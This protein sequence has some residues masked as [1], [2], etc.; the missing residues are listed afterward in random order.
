MPDKYEVSVCVWGDFACFTRP[1]ARV[2]RV[3]Y[4]IPP[5]SACRAI[6][7][8]ILWKPQFRWWLKRVR[9]LRPVRTIAI[10]RNE[11][12]GVLS[13]K[14]VYG[15]MDDPSSFEPLFADSMEDKGRGRT[16]RQTIALRDV[17]YQITASVH[18][19]SGYSS[20]DPP[21]KYREM[22]ERRVENG[23]YHTVPCFGC[24]EFPAFFARELP[25]EIPVEVPP[26]EDLGLVLLDIAK[27]GSSYEPR[28][29]RAQLKDGVVEF[30]DEQIG[31][32][33]KETLR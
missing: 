18:I 27:R 23:Q 6:L 17:A 14:A 29:F 21:V 5:P 24:R 31:E 3:S 20:S 16:Q 22:F 8:A 4:P 7:E 10:R 1:E 33:W 19:P 30:P 13:P 26:D 15:W 28:F 11:V 12:Q 32:F 2:E 9:V 25:T